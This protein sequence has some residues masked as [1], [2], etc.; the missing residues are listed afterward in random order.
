M[1]AKLIEDFPAES[2]CYTKA[3]D[4]IMYYIQIINPT[5]KE[6]SDAGYRHE[7]GFVCDCLVGG[8]FE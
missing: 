5:D 4:G 1:Y 6:F 3:E 2:L 8:I 7:C